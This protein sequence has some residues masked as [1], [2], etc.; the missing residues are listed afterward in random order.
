MDGG[1]ELGGPCSVLS[2]H[3]RH[4]PT[5]KSIG[6]AQGAPALLADRGACLRRPP[7]VEAARPAARARPRRQPWILFMVG[8]WWGRSSR[9]RHLQRSSDGMRP[10][11][12]GVPA[13]GSERTSGRALL[14][15]RRRVRRDGRRE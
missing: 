13:A 2:L 7:G 8:A 15:G 6:G 1:V 4:P 5:T 11:G 3:A 12:E 14:A 9:Q 10:V